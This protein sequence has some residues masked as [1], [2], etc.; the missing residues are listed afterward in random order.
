MIPSA[1]T[2]KVTRRQSRRWLALSAA[3]AGV[4][5]VAATRDAKATDYSWNYNAG[6]NGT[7]LWSSATNWAVIFGPGGGSVPNLGGPA[8]TGDTV[9]FGNAIGTNTVTV[10]LEGLN[11]SLG[12]PGTSSV[13][14]SINFTNSSGSYTIGGTSSGIA[15]L[16][17]DDGAGNGSIFMSTNNVGNIINANIG[18][19][20]TLSVNVGANQLQ[21]QQGVNA[22]TINKT[23]NGTLRLGTSGSTFTNTIGVINLSGGTLTTAQVG[24]ASGGNTMGNAT[25]N[26][27]ASGTTFNVTAENAYAFNGVVNFTQPVGTAGATFT[28]VA[29]RANTATG[30]VITVSNLNVG[31]SSGLATLNLS[32]NNSYS[33]TLTSVTQRGNLQLNT[34]NTVNIGSLAEVGGSYAITKNGGGT[35]NL[36]GAASFSGGFTITGGT[37]NGNAAGSFG[38]GNV[39][40]TNAIVGYNANGAGGNASGAT[41]TA[42]N[43]TSLR[44]ASAVTTLNSDKFVVDGTSSITVATT[45]HIGSGLL[46]VGSN[47]T[48]AN[49]ATIAETTGGLLNNVSAAGIN[50]VN[51]YYFGIGG[52][53]V[54]DSFT[55]GNDNGAT[56]SAWKGIS[57]DRA[58]NGRVAGGTISA[59]GDFTIQSIAGTGQLTIGNGTNSAA[60]GTPSIIAADGS[61]RYQ[62][63]LTPTIPNLSLTSN[64][65][66]LDSGIANFSG[67]SQFVVGY[68]A[69]LILSANN[70]LGGNGSGDASTIANVLVNNGGTLNITG[71]TLGAVNGNVTIAQGGTLLLDDNAGLTGTGTVTVGPGG[72][73][74]ITQPN[75]MAGSQPIVLQPGFN[76]RVSGASGTVVKFDTFASAG[77]NT[78]VLLGNVTN[79]AD[80]NFSYANG[81]IITN[82]NNGAT[83]TLPASATASFNF[84]GTLASTSGQ[85][86]TVD[87]NVNFGSN[88]LN[89]GS[90]QV[91][92]SFLNNR[93][94]SGTVVLKKGLVAGDIKVVGQANLAVTSFSL[95]GGGNQSIVIGEPGAFG[96]TQNGYAGTASLG[97]ASGFG[98]PNSGTGTSNPVLNALLTAAPGSFSGA[99]ALAPGGLIIGNRGTLGLVFPSNPSG[100]T[101]RTVITQRIDINGNTAQGGS[102]ATFAIN[103]GDTNGGIALLDFAEIRV[104]NNS[105]IGV[106]YESGQTANLVRANVNVQAGGTAYTYVNDS[107]D[108]L[109]VGTYGGG[110]TAQLNLGYTAKAGGIGGFR[111]N[112]SP[113]VTV[114][115]FNQP[116]ATFYEG[117]TIDGTFDARGN[118]STA[119][120]TIRGG[121]DGSA[122]LTGAGRILLG[123]AGA[124]DGGG[125]G[126]SLDGLSLLVDQ[127]P[128]GNAAITNNLTIPITVYALNGS[129]TN[130]AAFLKA[131]RLGTQ[132]AGVNGFAAFN[133]VTLKDQALIDLQTANSMTPV[134]SNLTVQGNSAV[135]NNSGTALPILVNVTDNG[136]GQTLNIAGANSINLAG[137]VTFGAGSSINIKPNARL[138]V[139]PLASASAPITD[140]GFLTLQGGQDGVTANNVTSPIAAQGGGQVIGNV[141]QALAGNSAITNTI[142]NPINVLSN[143]GSATNVAAILKADRYGGTSTGGINGFV[144][145]TNVSLADQAELD[146]Q[147]TNNATLQLA[148]LNV[149]G[150]Q[151]VNNSTSSSLI[152][153][154]NIADNGGGQSLTV[155]GNS[156]IQV[157]GGIGFAPSSQLTIK[158]TSAGGGLLLL[159]GATSNANIA[160]TSTGVLGVRVGE[161]GS[162]DTLGGSISLTGN[163]GVFTYANWSAS[164]ALVNKLVTPVYV[165]GASGTNGSDGIIG[166]HNLGATNTT[167]GISY[168]PN[169]HLA[170]NSTL[171]YAYNGQTGGGQRSIS[172]ADIDLQGTTG[173]TFGS[174]NAPATANIRNVSSTNA[175][176]TLTILANPTAGVEGY[177]M[178][179]A[180]A[181]NITVVNTQDPGNG[182]VHLT[183]NAILAGST[184]S[185]GGGTYEQ[186]GGATSLDTGATPGTTGT[187]LITGGTFTANRSADAT[188]T[189]NGGTLSLKTPQSLVALN[190]NN[191]LT[192]GTNALTIGT[193]NV[194]SGKTLTLTGNPAAVT[195]TVNAGS[196]VHASAAAAL[197]N[198]SGAGSLTVGGGSVSASVSTLGLAQAGVTVGT[199]GTLNVAGA[200]NLS[201]TLTVNAGGTVLLPAGATPVT[202]TA[203]VLALAGTGTLD[204]GSSALQISRG[205]LAGTDPASVVQQTY[206]K[207]VGGYHSSGVGY[208]NF[209]P[210]DWAG[211]GVT[212]SVAKATPAQTSIGIWDSSDPG[213]LTSQA[214]G[215][216]LIAPALSGDANGD[217]KVDNADF[218]LWRN[219]Y[220]THNTY[221]SHGDFNYDGV[222]DNADVAA[223]R[224]SYG[225]GA[226][227][228]SSTG[229][230]TL[231]G[232]TKAA[233]PA[234]TAFP[235]A[236]PAGKVAV[237]VDPASGDVLLDI[238]LQGQADLQSVQFAS[239]TANALVPGNY[240]GLVA[241]GYS[242]WQPSGF[243][244]TATLIGELNATGQTSFP[245]E[246]VLDLGNFY[247]AAAGAKDIQFTYN[248][249]INGVDTTQVGTVSYT[250]VPEPATLSLLTLATA[251]LLGRRR[252]PRKRRD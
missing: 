210:G 50:N 93:T 163:G 67:V 82:S 123:G 161:D 102:Q 148:T 116:S 138:I 204:L 164:S 184:F 209:A 166:S 11:R 246:V 119:T 104:A 24:G 109:N 71:S 212:S 13:T 110:G 108:L 97:L 231:T 199:N 172:V 83:L 49:G 140:A 153:V 193:M 41:F 144:K 103:R 90:A 1:T 189:Y 221:W 200:M 22:G 208:P 237:N 117:A 188:I 94:A 194:A 229:P 192:P 216:V 217:G 177:N 57:S 58:V 167:A 73:L 5:L 62:A 125:T 225:A 46:N 106:D 185:L 64:N 69:G 207:I 234:V 220:G 43:S 147:A 131:D 81:S 244:Q 239:A 30:K 215:T 85:T 36:T 178:I 181:P 232:A 190:V 127:A 135:Q 242:T 115:A 169:V 252:N 205:T 219:N 89:L 202:H 29:D 96:A 51:N 124:T 54:V 162:P 249:I 251:G 17:L 213:V 182:G 77:I 2:P 143:G 165:S 65:F 173:Y 91:Y 61:S 28:M 9:T 27:L 156:S 214:A 14:S 159:P 130:V 4:G 170:D 133:N 21:L 80:M 87:A 37:V 78:L 118:S 139:N 196:I 84:G 145:F 34:S 75:A 233:S 66:Q 60:N 74:H 183:S 31:S 92:D 129:N 19:T 250:S 56:S 100:N 95:N 113:N 160:V 86:L 16:F 227:T 191:N 136:G 47:L 55:V 40:A 122:G 206:Q 25:L 88:T 111:G 154:N 149:S 226:A 48:L 70:A 132:T 53:A 128:S 38:S 248:T 105:G 152:F 59:V 98:G 168:F 142:T 126:S 68:G 7:G 187:F 101:N 20:N 120:F 3:V 99:G 79:N 224:N 112:F 174:T 107:F 240:S 245:S 157:S 180:L 35:L 134:I 195:T 121:H 230:V 146:L 179:G 223:W 39:L 32:A 45:D 176:A 241:N 158:N 76:A 211:A 150:T 8:G 201:G 197:G 42:S 114:L 218:A 198:V 63:F 203:S 15:N 18:V 236:T 238:N 26:V 12:A 141:A 243:I 23:G 186:R 228:P 44:L 155:T 33:M 151:G 247:N 175:A 137:A 171:R 72:F 52:T 222:V 10:N 235:S 6:N